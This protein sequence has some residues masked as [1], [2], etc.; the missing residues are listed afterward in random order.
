[1]PRVRI[2]RTRKTCGGR[3]VIGVFG[4]TVGYQSAGEVAEALRDGTIR[5]Y[6]REGAWEADVR[7]AEDE[8]GMRL[9]STEDLLSQNNLMNLPDF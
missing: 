7:V 4:P 5:Y 8:E 1:M 9:V 2:T 3:R 6:V